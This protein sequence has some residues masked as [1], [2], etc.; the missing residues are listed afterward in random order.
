MPTLWMMCVVLSIAKLMGLLSSSLSSLSSSISSLVLACK[1]F[2]HSCHPSGGLPPEEPLA[3]A[4]FANGSGGC[5][6][7]EE[8][9]EEEE[10]EEEEELLLLL[11]L[12]KEGL[13]EEGTEE[14]FEEGPITTY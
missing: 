7:G 14:E 4:N 12:S 6:G 13:G 11:R 10:G 9:E 1:P 8:E 3:M 5:G 2:S